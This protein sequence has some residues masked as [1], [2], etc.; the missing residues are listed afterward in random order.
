MGGGGFCFCFSA[1]LLFCFSTFLLLCFSAS[2]FFC[3]PPL[4]S[5]ALDGFDIY[6]FY[7]LF[8]FI[9]FTIA[10]E[11]KNKNKAQMVVTI[12]VLSIVFTLFSKDERCWCSGALDFAAGWLAGG[13]GPDQAQCTLSLAL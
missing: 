1:F 10:N 3:F 7:F 12:I 6:L 5:G 2:L 11:N 13:R 8:F 4:L 9:L